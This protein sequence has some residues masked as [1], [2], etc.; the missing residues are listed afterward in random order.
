[1][2]NIL[3]LIGVMLILTSCDKSSNDNVS[4]CDTQLTC[5][6]E[7][8]LFTLNNIQG[9]TTFLNCYAMWSIVV[10]DDTQSNSWYIVDEWS[11]EY[12]VEGKEVTFCGYVRE[13]KLPL[14]LP[15]PMPGNFY[16]IMLEDIEEYTD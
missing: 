8:C 10:Q 6:D 11:D 15:D 12:K 13:N 1:M 9:T 3:L 4:I 14:L 16:Q 2:K 5:P 7:H